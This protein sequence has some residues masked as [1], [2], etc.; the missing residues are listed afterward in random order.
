MFLAIGRDAKICVLFDPDYQN[1]SLG[2]NQ[3][4]DFHGLSL[5]QALDYLAL[6]T[7]SFWKPLSKD[8]I[9][10]ANDDP[11]HRAA[12]EEQVTKALYLVNAPGAQ[13][14]NDIAN[15]LQK[16]TDIK[17]RQVHPE[18]NGIVA[19][20]DPDRMALAEKVLQDINK[21]KAEIIIDVII[22]SVDSSRSREL[23]LEVLGLSGGNT[24]VL[25]NPRAVLNPAQ[26]G[27]RTSIGS[28]SCTT[29]R[30]PI[31]TRPCPA[32]L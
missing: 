10:V 18:Q 16:I 4:L 25:F 11:I 1:L 14:V 2:L 24:N 5:D 3:Q 17:R 19:R 8:A 15:T 31:S 13:D 32:P 20:A 26:V 29:C 28:T 6:I 27:G 23:G 7:R 21:P 22:L 12:Y 9:F 30:A